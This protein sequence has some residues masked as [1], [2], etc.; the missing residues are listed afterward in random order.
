MKIILIHFFF[1]FKK[2]LLRQKNIYIGKNV[3]MI[4]TTFSEFNKI[5]EDGTINHSSI[6]KCTYIGKNVS[7][8]N[9]EI[10]S[11]CSIG[12]DT[13]IIHGTHPTHLVSTHPVFYSLRKQCGI[14]FAQKQEIEDFKFVKG[15]AKSVVIG[16]DVWIGYGVKIVEGVTIQDGAIVLAGAVVTNDVDAY[17]VVGG[18]PAKH[19]KYRFE[20]DVI[21]KLMKFRWWEKDL[22]WIQGNA[23]KFLNVDTFTDYCESS[24]DSILHAKSSLKNIKS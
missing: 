17:S 7:L 6:G 22:D 3:L 15:S 20:P 11:F 4:N 24:C 9:A 16:H 12:P 13:E 10:G 5:A 8:T 23:I 14:T 2:I 18:V 1:F 19:I 21:A